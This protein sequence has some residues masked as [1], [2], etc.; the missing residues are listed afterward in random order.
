MEN[1]F[2]LLNDNKAKCLSDICFNGFILTNE[3]LI[4]ILNGA[5]MEMIE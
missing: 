2:K 1:K 4:K 5:K 3:E